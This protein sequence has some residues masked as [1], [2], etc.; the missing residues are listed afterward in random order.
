MAL[1][2]IGD[3]HGCFTALTTLIKSVNLKPNDT[4]VF[5]GDYVDRGPGSKQVIDFIL[6]NSKNYNFITLR[7]NHEVMMMNSRIYQNSLSSWMMNGGFQTLDSYEI[8]DDFDWY[9]KIPE[10]HWDFLKSTLENYENGNFI[11]VH[12]GL[13]PGVE[14][15]HQIHDTLFWLHQHEPPPYADD[16][17]VVCGHTPQ[18]NGRIKNLGHTIFID[19]WAFN[20][21]WLTCLDVHSGNF[22]QANEKGETRDGKITIGS[23]S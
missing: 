21:E 10:V 15:K 9:K 12:A 3:I 18:K 1:Y 20:G 13:K 5:L 16:K 14:L 11:F 8:G 6:A 4:V 19:T 23:S 22:Y 7:G 2:A 17:I